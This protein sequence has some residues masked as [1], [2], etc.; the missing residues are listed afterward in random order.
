MP[1]EK[2]GASA[3]IEREDI[4]VGSLIPPILGDVSFCRFLPFSFLTFDFPYSPLF[5][6]FGLLCKQKENDCIQRGRGFIFGL[7]VAYCLSSI[8]L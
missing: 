4:A 3:V 5:G 8:G 2:Y 7:D 1:D 6:L